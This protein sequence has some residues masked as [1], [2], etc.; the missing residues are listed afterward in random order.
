MTIRK[1]NAA[2]PAMVA[3]RKIDDV[4]CRRFVRPA[5]HAGT[6]FAIIDAVAPFIQEHHCHS[7]T[8]VHNLGQF[9]VLE[10]RG[11]TTEVTIV[12]VRAVEPTEH[13]HTAYARE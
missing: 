1:C 10:P 9:S 8:R 12:R 2:G 5:T 6:P 4:P 13:R 7:W 11:A 3:A